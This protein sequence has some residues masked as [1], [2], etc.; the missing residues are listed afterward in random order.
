MTPNVDTGRGVND[1][2]QDPSRM[3][4]WENTF[5]SAYRSRKVLGEIMKSQKLM[6]S[7]DMTM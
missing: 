4:G 7:Q 5:Q 1:I 2:Q 6:L 3:E